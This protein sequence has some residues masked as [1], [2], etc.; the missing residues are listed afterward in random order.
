MGEVGHIDWTCKHCQARR[1]T[2]EQCGTEVITDHDQES[3]LCE[4]CFRKP[5]ADL[6]P[7]VKE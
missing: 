6:K 4:R 2:C 5:P 3:T 7:Q 1:F